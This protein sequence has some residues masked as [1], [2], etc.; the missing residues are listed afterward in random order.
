[1]LHDRQLIDGTDHTFECVPSLVLM[2]CVMVK[3][4]GWKLQVNPI[5]MRPAYTAFN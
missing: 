3:P 5:E 2:H 4:R 1:M